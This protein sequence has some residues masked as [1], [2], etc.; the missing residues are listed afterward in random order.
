MSTNNNFIRGSDL[1]DGSP[2]DE[3]PLED[4]DVV[5]TEHRFGEIEARIGPIEFADG[6][7]DPDVN[8]VNKR[9]TTDHEIVSGHSVY[10]NQG[11]GFVVQALGRR[12]TE[13]E[14]TGWITESQIDIADNLV[15]EKQVD[16]V[17]A[18]WTG[19]AVPEQVDVQYSRTYHDTHGWIFET[20][21]QLLGVAKGRL[22]NE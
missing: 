16:V 10:Q 9:E 3:R 7:D 12:P 18:R 19:T 21:F 20:T 6:L 22:R 5:E 1:G 13:L 2:R 17:S 14:V 11:T 8:V 4:R 15:S